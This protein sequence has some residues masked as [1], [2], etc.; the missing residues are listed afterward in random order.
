MGRDREGQG[1]QRL[2]CAPSRAAGVEIWNGRVRLAPSGIR[3]RVLN[4]WQPQLLPSWQGGR[5]PA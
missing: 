4:P 2:L 3:S 5:L 1:A